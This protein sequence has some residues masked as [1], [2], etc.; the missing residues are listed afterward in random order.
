ME[1]DKL[2]FYS[3][4]VLCSTCK[5]LIVKEEKN[6]AATAEARASIVAEESTGADR[7]ESSRR[8]SNASIQIMRESNVPKIEQPLPMPQAK[9]AVV[10]KALPTLVD[11][12]AVHFP[13][14][15][16]AVDGST[17][18][19]LTIHLK[20][21]RLNGESQ[22]QHTVSENGNTTTRK[23]SAETTSSHPVEGQHKR[24]RDEL[25]Q[26][27]N[28]GVA[29]AHIQKEMDAILE[30]LREIVMIFHFVNQL[31]ANEPARILERDE[32]SR[33]PALMAAYLQTVGPD[34]RHW[35]ELSLDN[36]LTSNGFLTALLGAML[37]QQVFPVNVNTP[38]ETC[39]AS[40]IDA[41]KADLRHS[42][43]DWL[44]F[45]AR[46]RFR[47]VQSHAFQENITKTIAP[48]AAGKVIFALQPQ[49][50][51]MTGANI[52]QIATSEWLTEFNEKLTKSIKRAFMLKA[53]LQVA[54]ERYEMIW[55]ASDSYFE[56]TMMDANGVPPDGDYRIA[57]TSLP[58]WKLKDPA[59]DE[60][61]DEV[62]V[63]ATVRLDR[64]SGPRKSDSAVQ[65]N[66]W[67]LTTSCRR[68]S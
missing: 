14:D 47:E 29:L 55:F 36:N 17:Q 59:G 25:H 51:H 38:C 37:Y 6:K 31:D 53:R 46:L 62:V 35:C 12:D 21:P 15:D 5:N 57:M 27:G 8:G 61:R 4:R 43:D 33:Y 45:Q 52:Q 49:F 22:N 56:R 68:V 2:N 1:M 64:M 44:S 18:Q 20:A 13:G 23:R 39:P 42:D 24:R 10:E 9:H 19:S 11:L 40:T 65:G 26:N 7:P 54:P 3:K 41:L 66:I 32:L 30:L 67:T 48:D 60:S 58:G 50:R 63:K 16:S 34:D 28:T